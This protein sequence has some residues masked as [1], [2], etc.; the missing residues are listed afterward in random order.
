MVAIGD[1]GV[2][3]VVGAETG[4]GLTRGTTGGEGEDEVVA[5]SAEGGE[6]MLGWETLPAVM[7]ARGCSIVMTAVMVCPKIKENVL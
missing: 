6:G 5:G 1:V 7:V 4:R 3:A 2:D